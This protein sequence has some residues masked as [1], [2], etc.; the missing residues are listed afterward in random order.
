MLKS[1]WF[2]FVDPHGHPFINQQLDHQ[3]MG[4]VIK[5]YRKDYIPGYLKEWMKIGTSIPKKAPASNKVNLKSFVHEHPDGQE[6]FAYGQITFWLGYGINSEFQPMVLSVRLGES[7]EEI[8]SRI[9][10][11]LW[12]PMNLELRS[13]QMQ[14][15]KKPQAQH[16]EDGRPLQPNDTIMSCRFYEK[17]RCV[18]VKV[19]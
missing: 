18:L 12:A 3:S 16:W 15:E 4:A 6:F 5:K 11:S 9:Q 7:M 1:R 2:T 8:K 19:I 10:E 13:C 14:D 17:Y